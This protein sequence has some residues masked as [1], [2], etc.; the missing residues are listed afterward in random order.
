MSTKSSSRALV[1]EHFKLLHEIRVN[2]I[3]YRETLLKIRASDDPSKLQGL[4][5]RGMSVDKLLAKVKP[6]TPPSL[7]FTPWPPDPPI[8][9]DFIP[10]R[11]PIIP[12][13]GVP[14][15]VERFER[16]CN[17]Y[18]DRKIED[19]VHIALPPN[20]SAETNELDGKSAAAWSGA[21]IA[22]SDNNVSSAVCGFESHFEIPAAE[23]ET[24][25]EITSRLNA[26]F[27]W[28]E[29]NTMGVSAG[30]AS[31][32]ATSNLSVT[33]NGEQIAPPA[34]TLVS[35]EA[36]DDQ[37]FSHETLGGLP[38]ERWAGH[39]IEFDVPAGSGSDVYVHELVE[40]VAVSPNAHAYIS[41]SFTWD[42]IHLV[43]SEG[44]RLI[45]YPGYGYWR[46]GRG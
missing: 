28:V 36:H 20:G 24:H 6:P 25:V 30:Y 5:R 12:P 22:F 32:S 1:E 39:G 3:K 37:I 46:P 19:T 29:A 2:Q 10:G 17:L 7:S 11:W 44:C 40:V 9:D 45:G 38:V 16:I 15:R 35:L 21:G 27:S 14:S 34:K 26:R 23:G 8:P 4:I 18:I 31:I 42:P 33:Y 41:G 43:M 13:Y